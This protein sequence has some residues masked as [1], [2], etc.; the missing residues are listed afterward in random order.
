MAE[1]NTTE[2]ADRLSV[3]KARISQYVSEG[4]LAGCYS[5]DGRQRRFDLDKV[6]EALGR[7]LDLGQMTGNGRAT[8]RALRDIEDDGRP[9]DVPAP[10]DGSELLARDP[11][12]LELATIQ[13]K[14]EEARR[15]RRDNERD[16]GRWV[17]AEDVERHTSRAISR[18]ISQ[19]EVVLRDG[20]RAIAD[21]MGVD[22]REA[23]KLLMD[24]WRIH[25][26]SRRDSLREEA[27][28]ASMSAGERDA[29]V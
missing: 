23:R 1:L 12:R 11:D 13:I 21:A 27:S 20:A 7:R 8:R 3:S 9:I 17:L 26:A 15:R 5:G 6:A 14:E 25:R 22:F 4:K 24:Q 19:F 2:L 18:E 29:N 16:E 10:R 28:A